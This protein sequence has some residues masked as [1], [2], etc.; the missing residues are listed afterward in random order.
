M[1]PVPTAG[2]FMHL[3][4][5]KWVFQQHRPFLKVSFSTMATGGPSRAMSKSAVGHRRITGGSSMRHQW[6]YV[7]LPM[8]ICGIQWR[9]STATHADT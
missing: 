3:F 8:A 6:E 4:Q 9:L 7:G 5:G 1:L 2:P